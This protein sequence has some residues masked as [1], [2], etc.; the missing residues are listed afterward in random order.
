MLDPSLKIVKRVAGDRYYPY[1]FY[2]ALLNNQPMG[3]WSPAVIGGDARRHQIQTLAVDVNLSQGKCAVEGEAI[4]LGF[5]YING[6]GEAGIA[7]IEAARQAG[8][9]A[10]LADFCRRTRL[11]RRLVEKLVLAGAFDSLKVPRRALLW[12]L[13]RLDYKE[14]ALDLEFP[15]GEVDLPPLSQAEAMG[16][17]YAI[18]GLSPGEQVMS[19]YRSWLGKQGILDSQAP[20]AQPDGHIVRVAGQVVVHQSPPTARGFH[21]ITLEDEAGLIDL[22]IRPK[23][24][25]RY[26]ELLR[27][28]SLLV[29]EGRVQHQNGVVNLLVNRAAALSAAAWR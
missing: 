7:R 9:F 14:D 20:A 12:A 16:L 15:A 18:L 27:S 13:G 24:Y 1:A 19:L 17:E 4:R 5:N 11:A 21:F 6:L 10:H 2:V 26:R 8:H 25:D 22:I 29:V 28:V 23:V 3:F